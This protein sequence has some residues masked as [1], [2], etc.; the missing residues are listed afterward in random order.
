[1]RN[2]YDLLDALP[3]DDAESLRAAFRKAAKANHP[4]NN[5]GDPDA[6]L[7]FRRIIRANAIL[8]D[9]RQRA[10]YDRLLAVAL[11]QRR[12]KFAIAGAAFSVALLG[13]Y[14]LIGYVSRTSLIKAQAIEVSAREPAPAAAAPPS[15]ATERT[16][17]R[18]EHDGMGAPN[19]PENPEAVKATTPTVDAPAENTDSA[20]A[21][22]SVPAARDVGVNDAKHYR[23]R[24]ILAYRSGDIYLALIDFDLAIDL[25][26]HFAEAYVDRGIVFYRMG[27]FDRAF[28]DIAQAKRIDDSNRSQTAPTGPQQASRSSGK[29]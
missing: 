18:D 20:A 2:L 9:E 22:A 25:D 19:E 5:L 29:N 14:L 15:D 28:A 21:T 4:D 3:D 27:Q 1:M 11:Q 7:R 17:P 16:R 23:E 6:P 12:L 24:G 10:H 8:S 26:P 13:G